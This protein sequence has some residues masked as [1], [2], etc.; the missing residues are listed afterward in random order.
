MLKQGK[1]VLTYNYDKNESEFRNPMQ[2]EFTD[3]KLPGINLSNVK[4]PTLKASSN[5]VETKVMEL[6]PQNFGNVFVNPFKKACEDFWESILI[7]RL[8][9]FL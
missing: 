3:V 7:V 2:R 9:K 8:N 1:S 4:W 6:H 5:Q